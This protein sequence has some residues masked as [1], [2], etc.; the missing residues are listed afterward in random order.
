MMEKLFYVGSDVS[1]KQKLQ[2][3]IQTTVNHGLIMVVPNSTALNTYEYY[4]NLA[5][6]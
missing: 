3:R 1:G 6:I 5:I 2:G 4:A